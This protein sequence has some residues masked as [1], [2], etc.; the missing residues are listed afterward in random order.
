MAAEVTQWHLRQPVASNPV[1]F[2]GML[3]LIFYVALC[4]VHLCVS[5]TRSIIKTEK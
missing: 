4:L 3:N 1:V 5:I 2:F